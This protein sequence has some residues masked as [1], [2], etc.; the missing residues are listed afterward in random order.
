MLQ[1]NLVVCATIRIYTV[2]ILINYVNAYYV[3]SP[4]YTRCSN[5]VSYAVSILLQSSREKRGT[6]DQ[7]VMSMTTSNTFIDVVLQ[8]NSIYSVYVITV[9]PQGSSAPSSPLTIQPQPYV[10]TT[11]QSTTLGLQL[12]NCSSPSSSSSRVYCI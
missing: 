2:I 11:E 5:P 1:L 9:G 3:Q 8:H 7:A 4:L 12:P 10:A 6:S